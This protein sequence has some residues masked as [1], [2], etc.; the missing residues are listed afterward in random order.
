MGYGGDDTCCLLLSC[1]KVY[2]AMKLSKHPIMLAMYLIYICIGVFVYWMFEP[3]IITV[4]N[5]RVDKAVYSPG[6]RIE[7][8]FDYC[9]SRKGVGVIDRAIVDGY[10]ITFNQITSDLPTGCHTVTSRDLVI[11]DF[12]IPSTDVYHLEG[13]AIY[14]INPLREQYVYWSSNIFTVK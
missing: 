3:G 8:T 1:D 12:I 7:Y 14:R 13:T 5:I 9:K 2:I 11:P 10:R 6:E 4:T